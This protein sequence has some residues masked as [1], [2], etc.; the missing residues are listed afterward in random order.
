MD[1]NQFNVLASVFLLLILPASGC[2]S[3]EHIGDNELDY[4]ADENY[5]RLIDWLYNNED[6]PNDM[7]AEVLLN[8]THPAFINNSY[9]ERIDELNIITEFNTPSIAYHFIPKNDSTNQL[10]IF[11]QGHGG[12]IELGV[13]QIS[14]FLSEGFAV[15]GYAM[16]LRGPNVVAS[17]RL[18]DETIHNISTTKH[19]EFAI[20]EQFNISAIP[21]FIDPIIQGINYVSANYDYSRISMVGLSG[22]GWTTV[23]SSAVD[24][25]IS[26]SYPVAGSI[27]YDLRDIKEINADFEQNHNRTV[28]SIASYVDLYTLGSTGENRTQIQIFNSV[29][30]CCYYS[31]G[32]EAEIHQYRDLIVNRNASFDVFFDTMND[33]HEI[34]Q[35]TLNFITYDLVQAEGTL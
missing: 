7:P 17:L 31:E 6:L 11:H 26:R 35:N 25:R 3:N 30:P 27:P 21:I 15:I 23:M 5:S 14:H 28:Y 22:G 9:I 1:N 32:R 12:G 19:S 16:P 13:E 4:S 24:H 2:L 34:S 20:I 33:G 8:V 29:D 18:P 10:I